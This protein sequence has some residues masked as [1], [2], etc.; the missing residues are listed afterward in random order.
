MNIKPKQW[1]VF[2]AIF[3]ERPYLVHSVN[4]CNVTCEWKGSLFTVVLCADNW[5]YADLRDFP[6]CMGETLATSRI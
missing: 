5:R 6:L 1:I 4:G 3:G 2:N